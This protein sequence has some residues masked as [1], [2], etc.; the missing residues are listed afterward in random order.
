QVLGLAKAAELAGLLVHELGERLGEAVAQRLG[1]DGGVVV[2]LRFKLLREFLD[3]VSARDGEAAEVVNAAGVLRCDKV[4]EAM[5]E[6]AGGLF[7]LLAE[8]VE[9]F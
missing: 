5:L 1:H 7:D 2:M 6:L 8:E 3:A 4:G 9:G